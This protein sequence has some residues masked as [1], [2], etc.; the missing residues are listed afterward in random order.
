MLPFVLLLEIAQ[1]PRSV[2]SVFLAL[3]LLVWG[4][5]QTNASLAEAEYGDVCREVCICTRYVLEESMTNQVREQPPP[6]QN[7][8]GAADFVS[9]LSSF[10]VHVVTLIISCIISLRPIDLERSP[11][12]AN[13]AYVM[14]KA[15]YM[16]VAMSIVTC[17]QNSHTS[18]DLVAS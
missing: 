2:G 18:T 12:I 4:D 14:A 8:N 13:N 9:F 11:V 5:G 3:L 16:D 7:G 1:S 17:T 15:D 10:S 6:R